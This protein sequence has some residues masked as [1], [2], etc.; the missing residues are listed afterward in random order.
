MA[1][2]GIRR[3]ASQVPGRLQRPS[4][5]DVTLF[6]A[7]HSSPAVRA[8]GNRLPGH[9]TRHQL[10]TTYD[11]IYSFFEVAPGPGGGGF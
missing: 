11:A 7:G 8:F 1:V 6:Y 5:C 9:S 2:V 3:E 10:S 4:L